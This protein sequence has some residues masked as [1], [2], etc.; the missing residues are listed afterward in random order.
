MREEVAE[1]VEETEEGVT[2]DD[3]KRMAFRK[4]YTSKFCNGSTRCKEEFL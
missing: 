3:I 1:V 2:D 4:M